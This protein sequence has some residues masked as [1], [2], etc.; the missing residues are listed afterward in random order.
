MTV[1]VDEP[2]YHG[3]FGFF[4][5]H[6]I[7]TVTMPVMTG[8]EMA[9]DVMDEPECNY[10]FCDG[11][12][13]DEQRE[14]TGVYIQVFSGCE[15]LENQRYELYLDQTVT[16]M[17]YTSVRAYGGIDDDI[18]NLTI[19][20]QRVSEGHPEFSKYMNLESVFTHENFDLLFDETEQNGSY[21]ACVNDSYSRYI[22]PD[23]IDKKWTEENLPVGWYEIIVFRRCSIYNNGI[24]IWK[25]NVELSSKKNYVIMLDRKIDNNSPVYYSGTCY[26]CSVHAVRSEWI[27]E[28]VKEFRDIEKAEA[29][30]K[31]YSEQGCKAVILEWIDNYHMDPN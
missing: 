27:C 13:Y 23:E 28:N 12:I 1:V 8:I 26:S 9:G 19:T 2:E 7:Y 24:R 4:G 29:A 21:I 30:A 6:E 31:E 25:N 10:V 3:G 22:A 5:P 20:L 15:Y 14:V 11:F 18:V 16:I 17:L